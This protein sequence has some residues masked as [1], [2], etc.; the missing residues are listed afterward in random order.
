ML[1][2][3][4]GGAAATIFDNL[5]SLPLCLIKGWGFGV[6][7]GL[8]VSGHAVVFEVEQSV[9]KAKNREDLRK[10]NSVRREDL[11]KADL[12]YR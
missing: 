4:H 10:D 7:R 2:N 5:T 6:S 8:N 9:A 11:A 1:G 3:L 12:L